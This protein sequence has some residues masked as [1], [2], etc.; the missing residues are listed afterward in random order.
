M[1]YTAHTTKSI[2][3]TTQE[4]KKKSYVLKDWGQ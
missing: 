3:K 4:K 1:L 2:L